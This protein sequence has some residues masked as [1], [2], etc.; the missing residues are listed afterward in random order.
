MNPDVPCSASC[1]RGFKSRTVG[2]ASASGRLLPEE[3][4]RRRRPKPGGRRRCRG[5]GGRCPEWSAGDW[6]ECSES[7]GAGQRRRALQCVDQNQQEVQ[8]VN[9]VNQ[10]RPPEVERCTTR[11][12]GLTWSTGDWTEEGRTSPRSLASDS[13]TPP[14]VRPAAPGGRTVTVGEITTQPGSR[15]S[16]ESV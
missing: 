11:A 8:E 16:A 14:G 5:R 1:G 2:C 9:C 12:C 4:C 15:P 6:G 10:I 3:L 13:M 7:C